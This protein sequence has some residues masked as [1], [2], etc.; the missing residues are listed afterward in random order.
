MGLGEKIRTVRKEMRLTLRDVAKGTGLSV[1]F[2]SKLENNKA[3]ASLGTFK[4]LCNFFNKPS[5]YFFDEEVDVEGLI[6]RKGKGHK[7]ES[8]YTGYF[9]ELLAPDINRK[10]EPLLTVLHPGMGSQIQYSHEGE[11]FNYIVQG[12]L[13]YLLGDEEFILE[14]GDS[15]YHP[16]TIPHGFTNVGKED[17]VYITVVTPPSF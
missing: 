14:E 15:I 17:C 13:Q 7:L 9:L 10:M 11:E 6:V 2:L 8:P 16:S 12:R 1:S 4:Q 3:N 5:T